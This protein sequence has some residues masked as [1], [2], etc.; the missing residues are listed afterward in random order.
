LWSNNTNSD[1]SIWLM[2][3]TQVSATSDLGI[4]GNGWSIVGTGD[5]NGDGFGDILWRNANGDTAIWLMT[6]TATQ[7]SVLSATDLGLIPTSWSVAQTGDFNGDGKS[8]ILWRNANGD[9]SIWLMTASGT[10]MQVLSAS[11]LGVIPTSWAVAGT[12][13]FNA[14]G[15]SDILWHNDNGDT[16]IWLMTASGT[17]VQVL[18]TTDLGFVPITWNVALTG[19][20]NGDGT[21][22]VLWRNING[23]TSIWLMTGTLAQVQVLLVSNLGLVPLSWVVQT[24]GGD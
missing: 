1:T 19:D 7:V 13:D 6:G 2:N 15:K 24:A 23:D 5:F 9:T 22:D 3:G 4:V 21:S 18:S 11:D 16:S 20:F 14:D 10:Q 17:Q 12:G 8:D